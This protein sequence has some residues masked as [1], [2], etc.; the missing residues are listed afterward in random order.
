MEIRFGTSGW[1]GII[2]DTFTFENVG[3]VVRAIAET[4]ID[5]GDKDKGIVISGDTRFL[6]AEFTK[7]AAEI[8]SAYGITAYVPD[9]DT[10][11]PVLAY[12][13]VRNKRAG[14]I[15]FTAS[16]NP[17][18]YNGIKFSTSCLHA[19][20]FLLFFQFSHFLKCLINS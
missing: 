4:V 13:V 14:V 8:I 7:F 5:A 11:T 1:R 19:H 20:Y 17:P 12:E 2:S 10:P 18:Q 9:R 15:N 6:S 3:L 16:H